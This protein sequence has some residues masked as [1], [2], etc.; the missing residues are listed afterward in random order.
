MAM[1]DKKVEA[2][3]REEKKLKNKGKAPRRIR[4]R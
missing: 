1:I 2:D 3:L 4:R